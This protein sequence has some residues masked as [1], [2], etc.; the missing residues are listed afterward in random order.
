MKQ[1][2]SLI[3]LLLVAG[4]IYAATR[5]PKRK[6]S[7]EV[8]PLKSGFNLEDILSPEEKTMYEL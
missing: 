2:G 3:I 6:G 1:K 8:G 5:K 7:V 4:L